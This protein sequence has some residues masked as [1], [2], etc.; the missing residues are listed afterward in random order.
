MIVSII[1]PRKTHDDY[2]YAVT[3]LSA[4]SQPIPQKRVYCVLRISYSVTAVD[5]ATSKLRLA[6]RVPETQS[7]LG[8]T[9]FAGLCLLPPH[10]AWP[11][12]NAH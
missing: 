8:C 9:P 4:G 7:P 5:S 11:P 1:G 12:V 6:R 3:I 10:M 2:R